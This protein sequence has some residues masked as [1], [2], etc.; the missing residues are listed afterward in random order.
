M[1]YWR[2]QAPRGLWVPWSDRTDKALH[3]IY[4]Q[5]HVETWRLT[6]KAITPLVKGSTPNTLDRLVI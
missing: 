3:I 2:P 6:F 5:N 1:K 4:R